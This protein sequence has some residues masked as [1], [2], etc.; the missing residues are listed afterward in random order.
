M[1]F[2]HAHPD[3]L[4]AFADNSLHSAPYYSREQQAKKILQVIAT[5][6][7]QVSKVEEM[8]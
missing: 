8:T 4:Q 6:A 7:T 1:S 3:Q 5:Q 2:C